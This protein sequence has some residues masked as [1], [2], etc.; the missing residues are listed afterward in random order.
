[1][2]AE[3]A[4]PKLFFQISRSLSENI[5]K[6]FEYVTESWVRKEKKHRKHCFSKKK[7]RVVFGGG[8][9]QWFC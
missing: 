5:Y 2:G 3:Q 4:R 8:L 1:M 9:D 6:M 7:K